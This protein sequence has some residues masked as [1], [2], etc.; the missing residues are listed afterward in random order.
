MD[1]K[2]THQYRSLEEV[3]A[4][5]RDGLLDESTPLVIAPQET[6]VYLPV[7]AQGTAKEKAFDG[8]SPEFLLREA[9]ALLGVPYQ[10]VEASSVD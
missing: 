9:L 1:P 3:V 2:L 5:Y 6:G 4:A 10:V 8:G 7:S